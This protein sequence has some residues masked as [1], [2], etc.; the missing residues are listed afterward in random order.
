M[1]RASLLF[2]CAILLSGC[3]PSGSGD[4]DSA[5]A[6]DAAAGWIDAPPWSPSADA[7]VCEDVIDLVFVLDTS[8][9]MDFVLSQLEDQIDSVV[10]AANALAPDAHFGLVVFQDNA[11]LDTTGPLSGGAVHTEAATLQTAFAHYRDVYT[12]NNRNPGDGPSG[13]TLQNPLCEENSLDALYLAADSFPW[14]E[15][16]TRVIIVATDDTFLERPD[17]YGDRDGDGDTTST[18]FPREGDYPAQYTL[19]ETLD[20]LR[21]QRTRVFSF[22]RLTVPGLLGRCDTPRRHPWEGIRWGWSQPY[23]GTAPIPEQT[24]AANFDIDQ[25][26]DGDLSLSDTIN[27]VVLDSYCIPPVL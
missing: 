21:A 9:S 26:R 6:A 18:D 13:A 14:R 11:H 4:D 23:L 16:A 3:G 10:S 5:G 7:G 8:S 12:A 24:D 20:R 25:V 22:T 1:R 17:N 19:S 15:S 27:Q 2:V